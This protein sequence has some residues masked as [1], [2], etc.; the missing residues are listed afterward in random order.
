MLLPKSFRE[1]VD[2]FLHGETF[3]LQG[4]DDPILTVYS[5]N[6]DNHAVM[7]ASANSFEQELVPVITQIYD[8]HPIGGKRTIAVV[9]KLLRAELRRLPIKIKTVHQQDLR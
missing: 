2:C 8:Q 5:W 7:E 3:S 1:F 4:E 6:D 9:V